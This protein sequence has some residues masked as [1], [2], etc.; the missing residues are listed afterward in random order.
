MTFEDFSFGFPHI[1]HF[2]LDHEG[3]YFVMTKP[4]RVW[5]G[6]TDK[7]VKFTSLREM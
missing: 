7:Y 2:P 1:A 6:E 5:D 3:R 4:L